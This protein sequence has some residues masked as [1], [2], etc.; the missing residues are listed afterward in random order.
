MKEEEKMRQEEMREE[1]KQTPSFVIAT[2]E[3]CG[4]TGA[5]YGITCV[6]C[7]GNGKVWI[8]QSK[9]EESFTKKKLE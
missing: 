3:D 9:P 8:F 7:V 1:K 2:C 5:I 6:R 4:G